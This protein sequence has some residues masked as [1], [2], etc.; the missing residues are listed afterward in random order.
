MRTELPPIIAVAPAALVLCAVV[1]PPF[2]GRALVFLPPIAFFTIYA[3]LRFTTGSPGSDFGLATNAYLIFLAWD[4]L[5]SKE[6]DFRRKGKRK[7]EEGQGRISRGW[8][9]LGWALKLL[10]SMRGADW[11]WEVTH[12]PPATIRNRIPFLLDRC[13]RVPLLYLFLDALGT[14]MHPHRYFARQISYDRLAFH[15]KLLCSLAGA[16]AGCGAI[17]LLYNIVCSVGVASF[18]FS[19]AECPDLFG[20]LEPSIAGFWGKTW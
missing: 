16:A 17:S 6:S 7:D 18:A 14:F 9:R 5:T 8:R 12:T 20:C 13:V 4:R 10:V 15:E 19:P 1:L 3:P 11:S 2:P